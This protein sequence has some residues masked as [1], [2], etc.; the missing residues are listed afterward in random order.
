LLPEKKQLDPGVP[1][2]IDGIMMKIILSRKGF[3]SGSGGVPSPILPDGRLVPLPIPA[4]RDPHS[5]GEVSVNGM[6]LGPLVED[7]TRGRIERTNRCHL[8]PDL[9]AMSLK[10]VAG[11]RPAFGQI[12]ASQ[13]HLARH[14]VGR[15]DLFLFFGWFR[16]IEQR[17]GQ[18]GYGADAP[19][20]HVIYGWLMVGDVID[21]ATEPGNSSR[22]VAHAD[23]PHVCAR[24]KASNTLYLA[25][26]QMWMPPLDRR[27]AGLFRSISDHRVLTDPRQSKRSLWRLPGWFHPDCGVRLS[28]HGK[29]DRWAADGQWCVLT[30]VARGQEFVLTPP[31]DEIAVPWLLSLFGSAAISIK[32]GD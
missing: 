20:L 13:G 17:G 30:S 19:E 31:N 25:A 21:L 23:H 32:A 1:N 3:D 11:W 28:Y 14:A 12:G 8:D 24:D 9:D 22:L 7:L 6:Q 5:Y 27:G 4:T 18:W 15:G 16:A 10:R 29:H 26:E 2:V